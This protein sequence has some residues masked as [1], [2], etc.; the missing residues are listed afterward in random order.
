MLRMQGGLVEWLIEETMP[1]P[2]PFVSSLMSASYD[3]PLPP[4]DSV[5]IALSFCGATASPPSPAA[6]DHTQSIGHCSQQDLARYVS[7]FV[8][9]SP[10]GP[11]PMSVR[12][13]V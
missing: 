9:R 13:A 1:A 5:P 12:G 2:T 3:S 7:Q 11:T 6:Y 10:A 8:W 4:P